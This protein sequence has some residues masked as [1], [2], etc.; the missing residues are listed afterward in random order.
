MTL[1]TALLAPLALI[2][3]TFPALAE[4]IPLAAMSAYLNGIK[5]AETTF[6]QINSDDTI[7]TGK[8][9]IQR[10]GR[11]RFEYDPPDESLVLTSGGMVAI[12]DTKSNQPPEQYPL[13][14]TPLNLILQAQVDLS[15]AKMVQAHQEVQAATQ[16]V[17]QDPDHPE[18]GSIAL[19]FTPAPVTLRQWVVT[20]D[21]GKKTTVILG[22]LA[23]GADYPPSQFAIQSELRKRGLAE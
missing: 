23:L 14:R 9:Y 7:S 4:K 18:Y 20:D 10:P 13:S 3:A 17:A 15:R 12:F 19:M 8:I 1:R 2:V 16:V 11:M 21:L 6:T 22:D 5:T